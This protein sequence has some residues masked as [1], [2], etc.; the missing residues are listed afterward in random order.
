[1][2]PPLVCAILP[3][4][5]MQWGERGILQTLTQMTHKLRLSPL[6]KCC[7]CVWGRMW[8]ICAWKIGVKSYR[9]PALHPVV[10]HHQWFYPFHTFFPVF[11]TSAWFFFTSK[12]TMVW[13]CRGRYLKHINLREVNMVQVFCSVSFRSVDSL[14]CCTQM[15]KCMRML[16]M[17]RLPAVVFVVSNV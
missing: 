2:S 1:M 14:F 16:V 15:H 12:K 10:D 13:C 7:A 5:H 4:I 3:D 9:N 8:H 11:C 17:R 6:N